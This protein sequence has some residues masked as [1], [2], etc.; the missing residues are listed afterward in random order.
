MPSLTGKRAVVIG[1]GRVYAAPLAQVLAAQGALVSEADEVPA[2]DDIDILVTC[3][4]PATQ[5]P[6]GHLDEA[7]ADVASVQ[8]WTT[9]AALA[10]RKRRRGAIVHVTGLGGL[11]GWPGWEASAPVFAALHNLT[12]ATAVGLAG[13]GIRVNALVP[14]VTAELGATIAAATGLTLDAV[15]ARIP[16]GSFLS[17]EA[18]GHAL[19]YLVHD[20][21]S[22]VSGEI[23]TVDG[24][25]DI[26]GRLHAAAAP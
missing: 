23:L 26:W 19:I 9:A 4:S 20:S 2:L 5:V 7:L 13:D 12:S 21:S 6:G 17:S 14:G 16:A 24:G 15:R 18:L 8:R 22:Y 1:P 11:G 25:W 3:P 10:M